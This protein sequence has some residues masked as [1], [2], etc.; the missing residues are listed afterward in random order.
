VAPECLHVARESNADRS[1]DA[2]VFEV[3][4]SPNGLVRRPRLLAERDRVGY[5]EGLA[6]AE[7]ASHLCDDGINRGGS[8]RRHA[9]AGYTQTDGELLGRP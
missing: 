6:G 3:G 2:T 4:F 7:P 8:R 1:S 5:R 9:C